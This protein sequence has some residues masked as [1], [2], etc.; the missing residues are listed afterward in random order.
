MNQVK[1]KFLSIFLTALVASCGGGGGG[2]AT[3]PLIGYV[4]DAPVEGLSYTC[5]ALTG[6]TGSDGSFLHDAGSACT[7]KIGNITIGSFNA[8][9]SDG[10]V[11]P[12][13]LAGVS[14]GDS[15]NSSAVAI[16]QF[17]QSL[18]DG[19][20][21][22]KIKIADSV[23][24]ALSTVPAQK[25]VDGTTTLSQ[26]TLTNLV[27][28]AT[29]NTKSLVSAATAGAAMNTFIQ[30]TYPALDV[31]KG[32]ALSTSTSSSSSSTTN[33]MVAA[34]KL[35]APPPSSLT[36]VLNSVGLTA[37]TDIAAVGY[38]VV[39]PSSASMPNKWQ[40]VAGTDGSNKAVTLS[41]S[42]NMNSGDAATQ[43]ITGLS[44]STEYKVYFVAANASQTSKM[45]D[46][47]TSSVSIGAEPK[48]P[49]VTSLTS[50]T[51]NSVDTTA[52]ISYKSDITGNGYWLVLSSDS[53]APSAANIA[54]GNDAGNSKVA[55]SGSIAMSANNNH[56]INI[57]GLDYGTSYK[58]YFVVAN[59]IDP[60]KLS[61]ITSTSLITKNEYLYYSTADGI[62][63]ASIGSDGSITATSTKASSAYLTDIAFTKNGKYAYAPD[64]QSTSIAQYTIGFDGALGSLTP[65]AVST[66]DCPTSF[67][68]NFT[69][70]KLY[71]ISCSRAALNSTHVN[72]DQFT[73]SSN[74]ALSNKAVAFNLSNES[75]IG[76]L[77]ALEVHPAKD[78][79]YSTF[80]G[81]NSTR[82]YQFGVNNSD[83]LTTLSP[84]YITISGELASQL[85]IDPK[86]KFLY[87][88]DANKNIH[89]LAIGSDGKLAYK[90]KIAGIG[91]TTPLDP[92]DFNIAAKN[93]IFSPN[94]K[95]AFIL[96]G[97]NT[98]N[99]Y[100]V[101]SE[102][103]LTKA[104]SI[105]AS[106]ASIALSKSG[107][108]LFAK[109][110]AGSQI[111][112]F[113][114]DQN[115]ALKSTKTSTITSPIPSAATDAYTA[116]RNFIQ[117]N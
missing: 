36:A 30:T 18:D 6:T 53:P 66:T 17:L 9:P 105:S 70:S 107:K 24:T 19:S 45:T 86:G 77:A 88:L 90:K 37:T 65:S 11:T 101:T 63:V 96:N 113:E 112:T 56:E 97:G 43:T 16:A 52:K 46:I 99:T 49:V 27:S 32:S 7:F 57:T 104:S 76:E 87:S 94:G 71:L 41:G 84:S 4:V 28:K 58:V 14:R 74:G 93:F 2:S 8:A 62:Q 95:F 114:I 3:V 44:F 33:H 91:P 25:I 1:F 75:T 68:T 69:D 83:E 55:L 111:L 72:L 12:H 22:G 85:Y 73:I 61:N 40:I 10:I 29:N 59:A 54:G 98:I 48:A 26:S 117:I 108:Y 23:V 80:T 21:S 42:F 13:D 50:G 110:V 79:V 20:G 81:T 116:L 5:G 39:L 64:S 60:T 51:I 82:I 115:G 38:Y 31:N 78:F 103:D 47:L 100:S 109:N 34:P 92:L 35:T 106:V 15:L 89:L 67:K 102:G